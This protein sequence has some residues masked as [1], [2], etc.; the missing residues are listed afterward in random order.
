MNKSRII[1]AAVVL[2]LAFAGVCV[3]IG[4]Q[5]YRSFYQ[6]QVD[7]QA[8]E[9]RIVK[10]KKDIR[11][12]K[13]F[14]KRYKRDNEEFQ[15]FLF[16]EKDVPEFLE[17]VSQFAGKA[18]VDIIDMKTQKFEEVRSAYVKQAQSP[19]VQRRMRK[20]VGEDSQKQRMEEFTLA[21]MPVHITVKGEFEAFVYFLSYLE[22]FKQLITVNAVEIASGTDYP[23]LR[24]SFTVKIYSLKTVEDLME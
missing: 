24:Y 5:S 2:C 9:N 23:V 15:K 1:I 19:V 17:G 20:R 22:K 7:R 10:L 6:L 16:K 11:E 12:I 14:I 4:W 18:G 8:H 21:A 3:Y 13:S